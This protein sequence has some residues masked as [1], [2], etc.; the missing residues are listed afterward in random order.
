MIAA[1]DSRGD[2]MG[3]DDFGD[4]GLELVAELGRQRTRI[5]APD[6]KSALAQLA[7]RGG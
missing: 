5:V 3:Q 4:L 1:D 7:L 2:Q 6:P